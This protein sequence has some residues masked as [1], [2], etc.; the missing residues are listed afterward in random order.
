MPFTAHLEE[1]RSRLIKCCVALAASFLVCFQ[2]AEPILDFLVDPLARVRAPGLVLIGTAVT[3]AFFT[4]MKIALAAAVIVSL[5]VLLWQGWQFVA[6]GLYEHEKRTTRSFVLFGSVFFLAGALF[7]YVIV[8]Q[9]GLRF[10]LHRY[11]V[12]GVQPMIRVA[13]YLSLAARL[14]LAFGIMFE[15]PVGVYFLARAG[16]IDHTFLIRHG[17]Y[18]AVAVAV[19][20]A[21][22]A[23]PDGVSQLLLMIPFAVLYAISTGIAYFVATDG[24]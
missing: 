21:V 24:R 5:P 17:R 12:I 6:P 1:L 4:K 8:L 23:P 19:V 2:F 10:L 3:E 18:A 9:Y 11:E 7:C 22:L 13:D 16:I 15:L 14:V 20:A